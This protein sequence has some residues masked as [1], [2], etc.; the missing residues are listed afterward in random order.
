MKSEKRF[1]LK[2][3]GN[4]I[5][6]FLFPF[7]TL[8]LIVKVF[9]SLLSL[10]TTINVSAQNNTIL[11]SGIES[12][13]V[14]A[15]N[16]WQSLPVIRLGEGRLDIDFDDLTH[17]YHR[18]VYKIEHCESDWTISDG[19]FTSD[20][21]NGFAEGNTIDDVTESEGTNT[22]Y[23]HYHIGIPN[24]KCS[25]KMSGNYMLTV[26]DEN[27]Y[28][29]PVLKAFF[30]V[31]E[32]AMLVRM[33]ATTNTDIDFNASHQ[34]ISMSINYGKLRV[35]DPSSQ[36]KTVVMKNR[37]WHDA[38]INVKPQMVRPDGLAWE[39]CR[40]YIF[41]AGNEYH[42]FEILDTDHPSMGV[43]RVE[44]D[45]NEYNAYISIDHP[46]RNYVYDKDANGSFLIRNSDNIDNDIASDYMNVHFQLTCQEPVNGDVYINGAW[47]NDSFSDEYKMKYDYSEKCYKTCIRLKLGYYSFKYL[48]KSPNG[49]IS[50]MP[51][52]GNFWQTENE[53]QSLIYYRTPS[54]RSDRLVGYGKIRIN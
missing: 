34:Q 31:E 44:W 41:N 26:S 50:I 29:V 28:D 37:Q 3:I 32:P 54:D 6:S 42:K 15:N 33:E 8:K 19:L 9:F 21:I 4:S 51:T 11:S 39:H 18:Y 20:I 40:E 22:Q 49:S 27:N 2:C 36:I 14:I 25:L 16:D 17:K 24:E 48:Q 12:L 53:F 45:G 7:S 13:T 47:T 1:A 43:E 23:T 35:T 5:F 10:Q 46:R 30:M 38:R 52:E